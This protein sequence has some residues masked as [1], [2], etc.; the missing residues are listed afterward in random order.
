MSADRLP[1]PSLF[2]SCAM[3]IA[4]A[5]FIFALQGCPGAVP[6]PNVPPDATDAAQA[7]DASLASY[8]AACAGLQRAGCVVLSDCAAVLAQTQGDVRF[9][10]YNV[11]CLAKVLT[12]SDVNACGA[13]CTPVDQ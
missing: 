8:V 1:Q 12:S 6:Q 10:Q 9:V 7:P 5:I 3:A 13:S 2:L 4:P 11:S